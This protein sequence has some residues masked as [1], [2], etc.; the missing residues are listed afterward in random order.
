MSYPDSQLLQT[1]LLK[2]QFLVLAAFGPAAHNRRPARYLFAQVGWCCWDCGA[3]VGFGV[4]LHQIYFFSLN[5]SRSFVT[6]L[7]GPLI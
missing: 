2:H 6:T 3:G 1:R 7:C 5:C 4:G